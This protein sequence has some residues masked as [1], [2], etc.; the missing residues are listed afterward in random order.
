MKSSS[1]PAPWLVALNIPRL[2]SIVH[3]I[4]IGSVIRFFSFR[5]LY[6]P[7]FFEF[8]IF[9]LVDISRLLRVVWVLF[10]EHLSLKHVLIYLVMKFFSHQDLPWMGSF[11]IRKLLTLARLQFFFLFDLSSIN[12]VNLDVV[13]YELGNRWRQKLD[14]LKLVFWIEWIS[15]H[16]RSLKLLAVRL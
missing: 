5:P 12:I 10:L 2:Q 8:S 1:Y 6:S 9:I 3:I 4:R 11:N 15:R 14:C 13:S 7:I 16:P